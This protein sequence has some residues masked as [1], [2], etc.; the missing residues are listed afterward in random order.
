MVFSDLLGYWVFC[1]S[2]ILESSY[3]LLLSYNI[4]SVL[5]LFLLLTFPLCYTF[6]TV[7]FF[8]LYSFF[9]HCI[10]IWGVYIDISSNLLIY[11]LAMPSLLIIKE[12][13]DLCYNILIFYCHMSLQKDL[14]PSRLQISKVL[15][16][17]SGVLNPKRTI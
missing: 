7:F 4:S 10:L 17:Y 11:S 16:I 14:R 1:L 6:V 9:S 2:L 12:G 5:C 15:L 13:L 3:S 8:F